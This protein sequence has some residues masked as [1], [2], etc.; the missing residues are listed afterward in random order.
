MN[1][2]KIIS[3]A[4]CTTMLASL[5]ACSPK[6]FF[7]KLLTG[8]GGS[9][10]NANLMATADTVN[11]DAIFKETSR[12]NLEGFEYFSRIAVS[13]DTVY[14]FTMN[15][16]PVDGSYVDAE[17][18]DVET[19]PK[20]PADTED[21]DPDSNIEVNN[22][23]DVDPDSYSD[24]DPYYDSPDREY[25]SKLK[26]AKITGNNVEYLSIENTDDQG[27][28]NESCFSA[29]KDGNLYFLHEFYDEISDNY[30]HSLRKFDG[31]GNLLKEA[32][33]EE[34]KN[35]N[36]W[37]NMFATSPEGITYLVM[38]GTIFAY[39]S[40]LKKA[41]R[42][43]YENQNT[44]IGSTFVDA[45]GDFVF[46]QETWSDDKMKSDM[47]V[48]DKTGKVATASYPDEIKNKDVIVGS[49]YDFIYRSGSSIY[50]LNKSDKAPKEI[51]N[52]FDSDINPDEVGYTMVFLNAEKFI[53]A[54]EG[55]SVV[56]YEK[57]PADQVA[58]KEII[59]IGC[60]YGVYGFTDSILKFN[61]TNDKYRIRVIDYSLLNT[62]ED[63]NAGSK[64]FNTDL[65]SGNAPD[66]IVPDMYDVKNLMNKGV[67]TDLTPLMDASDLKKSDFVY[68]AQNAYADG[69]KL[70]CVFPTFSVQGVVMKKSLYKEGMTLDDVIAWEQQTGCK[71]FAD[72]Y[73]KKNILSLLMSYGMDS[74]L[75]PVTGKCNFDS[76]EF[77][78]VLEYANTYP[79]QIGDD[80]YETYDYDSAQ[81]KYREGKTLMMTMYLN[82][83]RGYNYQVHESFGDDYIFCGMPVGTTG[84]QLSPDTVVGISD[85]SNHKEAA[86]EF[87]A[88]VF[89]NDENGDNG[90]FYGFPALTSQME[91]AKK[92]AQGKPYWV[93]EDG[94]KNYYDD[95][96]W[97]GGEE[98]PLEPLKQAEI[99]SVTDFITHITTTGTWDDELNQIVDE[100]AAP[101]FAGQK[102]A[103][104]VAKVIQSRLQIYINEKK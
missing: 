92:D 56:T 98:V 53:A 85:K 65:T 55:G 103:A 48:M 62:D 27:Y 64:R 99:D 6:D 1:I 60:V 87:I 67:F 46:T 63:W 31:N 73:D 82:N 16:E 100:E 30:T 70:Y 20:Q 5:V 47:F 94:N 44:W 13:G 35:G 89:K 42:Y 25:V 9:N 29:D 39:D 93:D 77:I 58:D 51:V 97:I 57:V 71:A 76:P 66:I 49:G 45:N 90:N 32:Q 3:V 34:S 91:T 8:K 96:Y 43:D 22:N 15:W 81:S 54:G 79:D 83:F 50:A 37:V 17:D 36:T 7:S 78:K 12:I 101:F 10:N 18:P 14:A 4:L 23:S 11:K 95:Y 21:A 28:Y 72:Y 59:T 74:F 75:D 69:D 61:K 40:D 86:W 33:V 41:G 102:S 104:D 19:T 38:D 88:S 2:K 68:C 24:N 26:V 84:L 52:F 80:Y